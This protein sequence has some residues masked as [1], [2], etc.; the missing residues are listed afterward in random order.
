MQLRGR[1]IATAFNWGK[2]DAKYATTARIAG[3]NHN[4]N[5]YPN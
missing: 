5:L 3:V 2:T 4:L 1:Y